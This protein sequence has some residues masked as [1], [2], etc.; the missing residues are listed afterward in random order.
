MS[1]KTPQEQTREILDRVAG[2][3]DP[4]HKRDPELARILGLAPQK[5]SPPDDLPALEK[6]KIYA[7]SGYSLHHIGT[8]EDF[9]RVWAE[10]FPG[11]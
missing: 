7:R 4:N 8:D 11:S 5:A 10:A 9:E 3:S 6:I 1:N 2:K